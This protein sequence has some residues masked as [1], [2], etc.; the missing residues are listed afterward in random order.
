[1]SK[2][3]TPKLSPKPSSSPPRHRSLKTKH[4]RVCTP[5][6]QSAGPH[7]LR[8]RRGRRRRGGPGGFSAG[9]KIALGS[10]FFTVERGKQRRPDRR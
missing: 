5:A 1:M 3:P 8:H 9:T 10:P 2:K 4:R 6:A 7:I